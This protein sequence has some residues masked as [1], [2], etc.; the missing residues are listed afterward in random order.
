MGFDEEEERIIA[1]R[2]KEVKFSIG[3]EIDIE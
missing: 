3:E 2:K 1:S